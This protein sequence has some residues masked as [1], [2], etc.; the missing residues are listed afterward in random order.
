MKIDKLIE[1]G[2]KRLAGMKEQ[3]D[4]LATQHQRVLG[5]IA[6]TQE[7][8]RSWKSGEYD[9]EEKDAQSD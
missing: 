5:A 8:L 6:D 2:E 9:D 1:D 7:W 3:A 4:Q